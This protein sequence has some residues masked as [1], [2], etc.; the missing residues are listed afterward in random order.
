MTLRPDYDEQEFL[1]LRNKLVYPHHPWSEFVRGV[2][3]RRQLH[4]R[5]DDNYTWS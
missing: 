2:F 1:R 4:Q 3:A 5:I